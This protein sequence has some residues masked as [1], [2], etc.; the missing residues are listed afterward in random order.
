MGLDVTGGLAKSVADLP[1]ELQP[2]AQA[3]M[4]S[5]DAKAN[6]IVGGI[7]ADLT[8]ERTEAINQLTDSLHGVLDRLSG[9]Q[10]VMG[11]APDRPYGFR[12]VVPPRQPCM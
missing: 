8:A 12:I 9:V 10:V 6:Q 4:D 7:L 11:A 1:T 3:L 2:V 5:L